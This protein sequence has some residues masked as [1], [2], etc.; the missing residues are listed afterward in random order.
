[1]SEERHTTCVQLPETVWQTLKETADKK[2]VTLSDLLRDIINI[3]IFL[4][5]VTP[6]KTDIDALER[7]VIIAFEMAKASLG[8]GK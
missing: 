1:V 4:L 2:G 8:G 7:L 5:K 6:P 3:Y